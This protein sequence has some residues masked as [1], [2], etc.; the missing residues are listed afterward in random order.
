[1]TSDYNYF[2][3]APTAIDIGSQSISG[4]EHYLLFANAAAGDYRPALGSPAPTHGLYLGV[5]TDLDGQPR[6]NPPTIGA[7]EGTPYPY[8]WLSK[9]VTPTGATSAPGVLTYTLE[10]YNNGSLT[11]TVLLTDVLPAERDLRRVGGGAGRCHQHQ[12]CDHVDG[13][14]G[15]PHRHYGRL[16]GH[17][18]RSHS[19]IDRQHRLGEQPVQSGSTSATFRL[20]DCR[21]QEVTNTDDSGAGSLRQALADACAGATVNFNL[22]YPATITLT[23]GQALT[24]TRDMT[25]AGPGAAKLAISGGGATRCFVV[26]SGVNATIDGLT[27]RNG[28]ALG[29]DGGAGILNSGILTVTGASFISNTAERG[30]GVYNS[31]ALNVAGSSFI[32]NTASTGGGVYNSGFLTVTGS[33]FISNTAEQEAGGLY[34]ADGG[35]TVWVENCTFAANR[36]TQ[37]GAGLVNEWSDTAVV[38]NSTFVGNSTKQGAGIINFGTLT[39]TNVSFVANVIEYELGYGGGIANEATATIYMHN[40]LIAGTVGGNDCNNDVD[41]IIA[42]NTN[43]LVEDGSCGAARSGDPLIG[44]LGEYGGPATGSGQAMLDRAIAARLAGYRRRRR[45]HLHGDRS[46]RHC[47]PSRQCLRHRRLRVARLHAAACRRR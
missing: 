37:Y 35:Y 1:M 40:I 6:S 15:G 10:L 12:R 18:D 27:I 24:L 13:G 3:N 25:I 11:D 20:V 44:S 47:P 45:C 36:A 21:I 31:G 28:Q 41:G 43:N 34:N 23:S 14:D 9:T 8:L 30:G 2:S 29:A 5:A 26:D 32:S 33:S 19:G 42:G 17:G 7:Y 39:A 4:T 46:A 16:H 38:R 22:T